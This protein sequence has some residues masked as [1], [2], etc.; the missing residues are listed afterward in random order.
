MDELRKKLGEVVARL[1]E[2][3]AQQTFTS[4][5]VEEIKKLKAEAEELKSTIEAKEALEQVNA[6]ANASQR[7][8]N[9]V[10]PKKPQAAD[11]GFSNMGEFFSAVVNAASGRMDERFSAGMNT[12]VGEDGGFLIPADFRTEIQ[13]KINGD[14]SLLP[15]T[16]KFV[17]SSNTLVLPVD[18]IAPWD[19]TGIQAYWEGEGKQMKESKHSLGTTSIRLHKLTALVRV[20]EELLE[21]APALEAYI[22]AKAPEAILHKVNSA[23]IGGNGVGMPSGVLISPFRVVVEKEVAQVAD[24]VVFENI[25]KM[26]A[27]VLP[28]AFAKSLWICTPKLLEQLRLMKFDK[29][30]AS[31]VPAYLPPAGL[32]GAPYGTLMG[33]PIMP[34]MGGVSALGDEGDI[35]LVDLTYYYSVV[36]TQGIKSDVSTHVYF[37][38]DESCFKF[39]FRMGGQVPYKAPVTTEKGDYK[40][41]G[42]IT[43][44]DR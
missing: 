43:L 37:D 31:P 15:L 32:A 3:S 22:K 33:R 21:D 42:I 23:I 28:A 20:T 14:E 11:K 8:T 17:T 41:S 1:Q 39:T 25:V 6:M 29:S 16:T 27:R 13:K 7:R 35:M 4:E 36:K 34:M 30:A 40:M 9:A 2:F 26:Q 24:T 19:G 12:G 5:N 10:E 18:E 44:Q 38:R